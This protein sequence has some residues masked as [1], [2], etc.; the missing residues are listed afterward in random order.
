MKEYIGSEVKKYYQPS[1]KYYRLFPALKKIIKKYQGKDVIDVG[2][3]D[4]IIYYLYHRYFKSYLG[5][6]ISKDMI[7]Q[8]RERFPWVRFEVSPA[9]SLSE[10]VKTE[11]DLA[12]SN[13]LIP[14]IGSKTVFDG[15]FQQ[16]F[17]ILKPGGV[18]IVGT[19]HP[20]LDGYMQV[21]IM[22][23]TD[24]ETKFRGYFYSHENYLVQRKDGNNE[25]TFSDY[26]WQLTDYLKA[27]EKSGFQL[28]TM[29]ECKPV[30]SL[31]SDPEKKKLAYR[32]PFNLI[33]VFRK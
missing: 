20:H 17:K 9:E 4:G 5:T 14:S 26:H 23:R 19:T 8:G 22:N 30:K 21:G 1:D 18:F 3:G 24:I 16:V 31:I 7:T 11:F 6:D 13:M 33:L 29:D 27:A 25:F 12:I 32:A 10:N 28:E 2:C 15:I